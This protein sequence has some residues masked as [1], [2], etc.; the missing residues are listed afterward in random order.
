MLSPI[1]FSLVVVASIVIAAPGCCIPGLL[2]NH[3]SPSEEVVVSNH[4]GQYVDSYS[5]ACSECSSCGC[6]QSAVYAPSGTETYMEMPSQY[7]EQSIVDT[8]NQSI[9]DTGS[10]ISAETQGAFQIQDPTV[11]ADSPYVSGSSSK[12]FSAGNVM[13]VINPPA[14]LKTPSQNALPGNLLP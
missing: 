9:V 7:G 10:Q 8:G 14:N 12:G 1:K 3:S 4:S 11:Q 13:D 2:C 5:G 6:G